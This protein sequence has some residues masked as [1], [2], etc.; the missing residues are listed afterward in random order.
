MAWFVVSVVL[1]YGLVPKS[2]W[3]SAGTLIG[4]SC[5]AR[6]SSVATVLVMF[7]NQNIVFSR[8]GFKLPAPSQVS[9][10]ANHNLIFKKRKKTLHTMFYGYIMESAWVN[11]LWPSD[12][13]WRQE[14]WDNIGL[15]ND[16]VLSR[17]QAI[18][19]TNVDLLPVRFSDILVRGISQEITHH[20]SLNLVWKWCI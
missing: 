5:I 7:D 3:P 4:K 2:A 8:E 9:K 18:T 11:S 15:G 20:H 17:H 6:P 14:I 19:W 1:D 16:L 10:H 12:S 13:T